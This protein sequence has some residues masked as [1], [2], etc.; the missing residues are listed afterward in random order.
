MRAL[1]AVLLGTGLFVLVFVCYGL[2]VARRLLSHFNA[3]SP[4]GQGTVGVDLITLY[5]NMGF[6]LWLLLSYAVCLIVGWFIAAPRV[7]AR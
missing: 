1:K 3:I 7:P 5:H 2:V 4:Q 6:P